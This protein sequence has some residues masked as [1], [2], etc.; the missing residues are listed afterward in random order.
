LNH[1]ANMAV[2][3]RRGGYAHMA[4]DLPPHDVGRGRFA[5]AVKKAD[6][7]PPNATPVIPHTPA[8]SSVPKDPA[9]LAVRREILGNASELNANTAVVAPRPSPRIK[10]RPPTLMPDAVSGDALNS[11]YTAYRNRAQQLGASRNECLARAATA[12]KKGDGT[13]AKRF[14][15][16]GHDLNAKMS[17]ELVQAAGRLVR[18]RAKLIEQALRSSVW[19]DDSAD[20]AFSAGRLCAAGLGVCLGVAA[21]AVASQAVGEGK[22]LTPDERTEVMIDLHGLQVAEATEVIEEFLLAVS[23]S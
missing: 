17:A 4:H 8:T 20:R 18:E 13:A 22:K 10:L 19:T 16:E 15:R 3:T 9:T 12:W 5:A 6:P 2:K 7:S 14:T 11:L 23:D 21:Q 1:A